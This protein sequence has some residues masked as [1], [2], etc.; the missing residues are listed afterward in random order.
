MRVERR[1]ARLRPEYA[2]LYP[3]V[4]PGKWR[5]IGELLDCVAVA[6]LHAGRRSGEFLQGR[7][8]DDGH[9]EFRGGF[10][11]PPGR[12]TRLMDRGAADR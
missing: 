3:G 2:G 10:Q 7:L 6:R 1:Q 12:H 5:P 8:L 4:P 11:R 9:F